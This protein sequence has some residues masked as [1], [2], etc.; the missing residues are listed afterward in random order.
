MTKIAD[1]FKAIVKTTTGYLE[2]GAGPMRKAKRLRL[3]GTGPKAA[4]FNRF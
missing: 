2:Q 4:G 1:H 3:V